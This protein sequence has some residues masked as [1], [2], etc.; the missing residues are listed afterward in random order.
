MIKNCEF[1]GI[2][3]ARGGSKRIPGKNLKVIYNKP[4]IDWTISAAIESKYLN[5]LYLSTDSPQIMDSVTSRFTLSAFGLRA[6][7]LA[8]DSASSVDVVLD[9]LQQ[10]EERGVQIGNIVLLQP[11][12]PLRDANDIDHAIKIFMENEITAVQAYS[13]AECPPQWIFQIDTNG[14]PVGL[15]V[16]GIKTLA[17]AASNF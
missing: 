8:S 11:T 12:S 7:T 17:S 9:V 4:L 16:Q 10:Y 5:D 6:A 14:T 13:P 1:L 3:T 15:G 2:I